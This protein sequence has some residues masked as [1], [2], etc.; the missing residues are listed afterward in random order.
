MPLATSLCLF[1]AIATS[2]QISRDLQ[3]DDRGTINELLT[4][5]AKSLD[6]SIYSVSLLAKY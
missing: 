6:L 1:D 3:L 2:L 4:F 5:D